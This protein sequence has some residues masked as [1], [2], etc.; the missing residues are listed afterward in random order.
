MRK[1]KQT[2]VTIVIWFRLIMSFYWK[3]LI[4][5]WLIINILFFQ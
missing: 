4:F 3:F 5:I 1:K 2:K